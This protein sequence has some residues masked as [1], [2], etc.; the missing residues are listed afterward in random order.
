M[1]G[2]A[3]PTSHRSV[4][5]GVLPRE[6]TWDPRGPGTQAGTL[7]QAP[8]CSERSVGVLGPQQC[9]QA[10]FAPING[11]GAGPPFHAC[12]HEAKEGHRHLSLLPFT[13]GDSGRAR[14]PCGGQLDAAGASA[15]HSGVGGL[16]LP[17]GILSMVEELE[18]SRERPRNRQKPPT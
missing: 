2:V 11:A 7:G 14:Q 6:D 17:P 10:H 5:G 13:E 8:Q 12:S 1:A 4:G 16:A 18:K 15:G 3:V 9:P